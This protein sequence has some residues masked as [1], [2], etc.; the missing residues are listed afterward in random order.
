[1]MAIFHNMMHK[2][3]EDYVDDIVVKSKISEGHFLVLVQVF[4]RC[5]M[6][7]LCMNPLNVPSR[8]FLGSSLCFEFII[9]AYVWI[10]P[11][12]LPLQLGKGL[13][14]SQSSKVS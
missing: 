6:Y 4:E 10:Q 2:E 14:Q 5:R 13:R 3:T 9:E 8:Y 11:R 1:M 7:K 12:P